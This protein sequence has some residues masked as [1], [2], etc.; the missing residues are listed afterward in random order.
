DTLVEMKRFSE[1]LL[2]LENVRYYPEFNYLSVVTNDHRKVEG[3]RVL[4]AILVKDSISTLQVR[5]KFG[6]YPDTG[7]IKSELIK[8]SQNEIYDCFT[9]PDVKNKKLHHF[10]INIY[11]GQS[12]RILPEDFAHS[13]LSGSTGGAL[14]TWDIQQLYT[15]PNNG[16]LVIPN[17]PS[18]QDRP[19]Y[20]LVLPDSF[21][22]SVKARVGVHIN[23]SHFTAI[24]LKVEDPNQESIGMSHFVVFNKQKGE[25]HRWDVQGSNT[26]VRGFD[27]WIAG[28]IV[29]SNVML[30][31]DQ[32]DRLI[33][34]IA[35][36]RVSPGKEARRQKGST[37]GIPFDFRIDF[38]DLFYPGI[39]FA[40]NI[41]TGATIN[42]STG[43]GDSEILLV[44][45][46]MIYYRI[47]DRIYSVPLLH[48]TELGESKLLIKDERV[49]DIHWAFFGG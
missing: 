18:I 48:G 12:R 46:E 38:Y 49:P 44:E 9:C 30:V 36:N 13:L 26:S 28:N 25:W 4:Q 7:C 37:T 14:E 22:L 23:N 35:L 20:P 32:Q 42:W 40:H 27:N 33:E 34:K 10:G 17:T 6:D 1:P 3:E 19:P 11:T 45:N 31:F 15:N 29:T 5:A 8:L 41:S 24:N 43:Q 39:L 2:L 16:N 47:N 21:Q